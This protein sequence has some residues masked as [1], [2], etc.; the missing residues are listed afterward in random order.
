MYYVYI[1]KSEINGSL[2]KGLSINPARRI[3]E[4]NSGKTKST[5]PY[6]PWKIVLIEEF[7]NLVEAR[8]REKYLKSGTG[9]EYLKSILDP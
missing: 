7:E 3:K 9:R 4:H 1:I 5:R 6:R 2:Y 8:N